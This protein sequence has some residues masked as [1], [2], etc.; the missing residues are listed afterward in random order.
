MNNKFYSLPQLKYS[1]DD[2]TPY[3]SRE[4]L[5]IHHEK[6]HS[7]YVKGANLILEKLDNARSVG[8]ELDLKSELKSLSFNIGGHILHSLFWENVM[9]KENGGGKQ[10]GEILKKIHAEFGSFDRFKSEFSL[11]AL[12]VEGS[13]WAALGYAPDTGRLM[14]WQIEKHN[15]LLVPKLHLLLVVDVF[16]HAYYMDYKNDRAKFIE[17]FW[18]IINWDEVNRRYKILVKQP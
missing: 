1:Y 4:Q 3:I 13:G 18:E 7:S 9:P 11:A 8:A 16:E 15:I 14:V 2:L 17:S 10:N 5:K 6:H 12:S